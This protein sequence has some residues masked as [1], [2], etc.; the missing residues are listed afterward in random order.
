MLELNRVEQPP[1]VSDGS[2]ARKIERCAGESAPL[3]AKAGRQLLMSLQ[4][5]A[6]GG[7]E[8][9]ADAERGVPTG[10]RVGHELGQAAVKADEHVTELDVHLVLGVNHRRHAVQ[11]QPGDRRVELV[12]DE[13]A[14][15]EAEREQQSR[16]HHQRVRAPRLAHRPPRAQV[17]LRR[18]ARH[19][20]L[21]AADHRGQVVVGLRKRRRRPD[22]RGEHGV[23]AHR[24]DRLEQ[25]DQ[26]AFIELVLALEQLDDA[27][28]HLRRLDGERQGAPQRQLLLGGALAE[29]ERAQHVAH[30]HGRGVLY[31]AVP[32]FVFGA[33][34]PSVAERHPAVAVAVANHPPAV[35]PRVV[36]RFGRG[37]AGRGP[38][39]SHVP[40]GERVLQEVIGKRALLKRELKLTNHLQPAGRAR[41]G[42]RLVDRLAVVLGPRLRRHRVEVGAVLQRQ[43]VIAPLALEPPCARLR[44]E[45]GRIA[46][47]VARDRRRVAV[48]VGRRRAVAATR[49]LQARSD[50]RRG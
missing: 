13:A 50:P 3:P 25:R 21:E 8:R 18:H 26:L 36:K 10:A 27:D 16:I 45:L 32:T 29:H 17:G 34:E 31:V 47:E 48:D 28:V 49:D 14:E 15:A 42:Q 38:V 4:R 24:P 37:G 41:A 5:S 44:H 43:Q 22:A 2:R 40:G 39:E 46:E 33:L 30:R 19:R 9:V 20:E 35:V 12:A 11:E 6:A 7:A 1:T 23:L